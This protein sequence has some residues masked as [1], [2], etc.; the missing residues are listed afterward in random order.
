[1]TSSSTDAFTDHPRLQ[2]ERYFA[3]VALIDG[4]RIA[5]GASDHIVLYDRA[6]VTRER[7]IQLDA[8]LATLAIVADEQGGVVTTGWDGTARVDLATGKTLWRRSLDQTRNCI[9]LHLTS[10]TTVACGSFG[11]LALLDISTGET[12]EVQADL[13]S[14][15][16]PQFETIDDQTLLVFPNNPSVWMRW[17]LDGGGAGS[18][19]V[20]NGRELADGSEAGGTLIVTQPRGGGRMQLWDLERDVPVGGESDR[21]VTLG[22]GVVARF[23]EFELTSRLFRN[24]QMGEPRLERVSTGEEITL[25]VPDLPTRFNV[26]SGTSGQVA[27]AWWPESVVAFDPSSGEPLGPLMKVPS[28]QFDEVVSASETPDSALAVITWAEYRSGRTETAVFEI[29]TGE[30]LV[31]G[32]YDLHTSRVLDGRHLVGIAE[33]YARRYDLRTLEPVSALAKSIGGGALTSLSSD[34]R[35]LLNVGF[36]NTLMLYDLAADVAIGSPIRSVVDATRVP[37]GVLA[38]HGQSLLEA[39]PDGIRVWDLRPAEQASSACALAGRALTPEEWAI[40]FPAEEQVDTCA[41]L[42]S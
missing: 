18:N 23:D 16:A 12:Q 21:I 19:I 7:T 26:M 20:G 40:Y 22:S 33:D 28:E 35:T 39:L 37:G 10:E 31:R 32:L 27:F 14:G 15:Y 1:V 8:D 4:N 38:Q 25:A 30:L 36:D 29:A 17:R 34:G 3:G 41:E 24:E 5:V 11:G 42:A 9:S 13:Q 2:D 6:T